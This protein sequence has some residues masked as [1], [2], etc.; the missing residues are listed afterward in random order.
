[1]SPGVF[2]DNAAG[3]IPSPS[4]NDQQL[5]DYFIATANVA[6]KYGL[7]SIHDAWS[8]MEM[9]ALFKRFIGVSQFSS[10]SDIFSP[11]RK[12]EEDAIPVRFEY[13]VFLLSVL[14]Q[15]L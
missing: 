15:N 14:N 2:V 12:A 8:P 6:L 5:E 10:H 1:L 7:T 3:L 13:S 11:Q 9:I 4:W